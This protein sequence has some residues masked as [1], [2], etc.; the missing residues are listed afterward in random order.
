MIV[1]MNRDTVKRFIELLPAVVARVMHSFHRYPY[2]AFIVVFLFSILFVASIIKYTH[3]TKIADELF[4]SSLKVENSLSSLQLSSA[5]GLEPEVDKDFLIAAWYRLDRPIS[6]GQ[7]VTLFSKVEASHGYALALEGVG[8]NNVRP[9]V[10]WKEGT[11][12]KWYPMSEVEIPVREWFE[13][14]LIFYKDKYLGA[15]FGLWDPIK[16]K[17]SIA[18]LG[19]HELSTS[20][21]PKAGDQPLVFGP[22]PRGTFKG[23]IGPIL[24]AQGKK[25]SKDVPSVLK[26]LSKYPK[27]VPDNL[28]ESQVVAWLPKVPAKVPVVIGQGIVVDVGQPVKGGEER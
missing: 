4:P 27:L 24:I 12:G 26:H 28:T 21:R 7:K 1:V 2:A 16:D 14:G 13:I 11:V 10:L 15:H 23:S 6:N 22:L 25:L 17:A 3:P 9:S 19:G 5:Q 18:T 8:D 20:V